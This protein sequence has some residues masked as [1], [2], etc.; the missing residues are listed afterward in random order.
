MKAINLLA[1]V[2]GMCV[3]TSYVAP[4]QEVSAD[5]MEETATPKKKKKKKKKSKKKKDKKAPASAV[6]KALKKI[7]SVNGKPNQKALV[8]YYLQSASWCGPCK[9]AM[10]DIVETYKE[11]RED[12]RAEIILVG[13]D[14][15]PEG[16]KAY[17]SGYKSKMPAVQVQAK[18]VDKLPGF[19]LAS[20]IPNVIVVSADG[21]VITQGYPTS[22]I[23]QWKAEVERIEAAAADSDNKEAEEESTAAEE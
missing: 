22:I 14:Q 8:Y 17:I 9:Q 21:N 4:A 1:L 7:K 10:P 13:H 6:G 23:P 19:S 18:N 15:T 3:M 5:P 11:M 12:G 20:G 16:V 2:L